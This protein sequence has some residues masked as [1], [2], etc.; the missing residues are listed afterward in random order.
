MHGPLNVKLLITVKLFPM[1]CENA[2]FIV[3]FTPLVHFSGQ[4]FSYDIF[5]YSF[6]K[7]S[8]NNLSMHF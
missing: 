2:S 3:T 4:M 5:S 6:F 8:F 1:L 7:I